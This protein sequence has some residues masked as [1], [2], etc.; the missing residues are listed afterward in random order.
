VLVTVSPS[1]RLSKITLPEEGAAEIVETL[2]FDSAVAFA[3]KF[4]LA[5]G[6]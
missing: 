2:S 1:F 6:F 4:K 3:G 5:F